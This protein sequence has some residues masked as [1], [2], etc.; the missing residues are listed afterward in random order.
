MLYVFWNI[1]ITFILLWN[2]V[3]WRKYTYGHITDTVLTEN[4]I[5]WVLLAI[6]TKLQFYFKWS[7]QQFKWW[8]QIIQKWVPTTTATT[9]TTAQVCWKLNANIDKEYVGSLGKSPL[10]LCVINPYSKPQSTQFL[11][12]S[13]FLLPYIQ[14][15]IN[16][17]E[18]IFHK[19]KNWRYV[20]IKLTQPTWM[21]AAWAIY[22]LCE[23]LMFKTCKYFKQWSRVQNPHFPKRNL[24]KWLC[25][26]YCVQYLSHPC[27]V[28]D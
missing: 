21:L 14:L 8:K 1:T 19:L 15:K 23:C 22:A 18:Q 2:F 4:T 28:C 25:Q 6:N 11:P 26:T 13:T 9:I 12:P 20:S 27:W 5:L 24:K 10:W 16:L 17:Q 7:Q 3:N